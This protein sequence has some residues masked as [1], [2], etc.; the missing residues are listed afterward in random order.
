MKIKLLNVGGAMGTGL[1][2]LSLT[3]CNSEHE[4]L[5][6]PD[7]N[8]ILGTLH[9]NQA[10]AVTLKTEMDP[11]TT[12][13]ARPHVDVLYGKGNPPPAEA[14]ERVPM[15]IDE[16][17][18]WYPVFLDKQ[19]LIVATAAEIYSNCHVYIGRITSGPLTN[20]HLLLVVPVGSQS[21]PSLDELEGEDAV[22]LTPIAPAA[23]QP[24]GAPGRD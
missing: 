11:I 7:H 17:S 4:V 9:M 1:L 6:V 14:F 22:Y 2:L 5:D 15:P 13:D 8:S 3:A 20:T 24:A 16:G 18:G 10:Y 23:T 19:T 21:V 12:S